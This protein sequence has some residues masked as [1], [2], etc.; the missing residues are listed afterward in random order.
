MCGRYDDD[1]S[2]ATHTRP[3]QGTNADVVVTLRDPE[4]LFEAPLKDKTA[5]EFI[6]IKVSTD[7]YPPEVR[8]MLCAGGAQASADDAVVC[9]CDSCSVRV[10][11]IHRTPVLPDPSPRMAAVGKGAAF[12]MSMLGGGGG[13]GPAL[14][15]LA[16][17]QRMCPS[18][19]V[20]E[21]DRMLNPFGLEMGDREEVRQVNGALVGSIAVQTFLLLTS[22]TIAAIMYHRLK[23]KE[24][25]ERNFGHVKAEGTDLTTEKR[26]TVFTTGVNRH[27]ITYLAARGR[28]GWILIPASFLYAGAAMCSMS[29]LLYST[30]LFKFIAAMDILIFL[31]GLI[32]YA[33]WVA[34]TLPGYCEVA[35][36]EGNDERNVIFK[37][38]WG[39]RE[40]VT[41]D[42]FGF[43]AWVELNHMLYDGYRDRFRF[44][45]TYELLLNLLLG[46]VGAWNPP[47]QKG[48]YARSI[49]TLTLM[50]LFFSLLLLGRPYLSPFENV[51]E[52]MIAG[53]EV[54]MLILMMI[55]TEHEDPET[56]VTSVIASY[57]GFAV[58][59]M[60]MTKTIGD[61]TIFVLDERAV[62][63]EMQEELPPG[64]RS[65]FIVHLL[66]CGNNIQG[67]A[68]EDVVAQRKQGKGVTEADILEDY[69]E[70]LNREEEAAEQ[71]GLEYRVGDRLTEGS[72][73]RSDS[74]ESN[75]S[76]NT[77]PVSAASAYE[78]PD[79]SAGLVSSPLATGRTTFGRSAFASS[80]RLPSEGST[81]ELVEEDEVH[82]PVVR[83]GT[84]PNPMSAR[85]IS[86]GLN[87]MQGAS[88]FGRGRGT[89]RFNSSGTISRKPSA[90]VSPVN[91]ASHRLRSGSMT[92]VVSE[93][94]SFLGDSGLE[95]PQPPTRR[96][97][98]SSAG[99]TTFGRG[100]GRSLSVVNSESSPEGLPRQLSTDSTM[101]IEL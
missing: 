71:E 23:G 87:T 49:V 83:R 36:C 9:T 24:E 90:G 91:D 77:M 38:F 4:A 18:S 8:E 63:K 95:L 17:L 10:E 72:G 26:T 43:P 42:G 82:V 75:G 7:L 88:V 47:N 19:D 48:C 50:I 22:V 67:L 76:G 54:A 32:A 51:M 101:M 52:T 56:H 20:I 68:M 70:L 69:R 57:L 12:T 55:A 85:N 64:E 16:I 45:L 59:Y 27:T 28:F 29:A 2:L 81:T 40:W 53:T 61:L 34:W 79:I 93:S 60:I 21:L 94:N 92:S 11:L 62:W 31:V 98:S 65:A 5:P 74:N 25:L 84:V 41:K 35:D 73:L 66:C 86:Y 46:F 96:R 33:L 99:F 30:P 39:L 1:L 97:E 6:T 15:K 89:S 58:I 44:F 37:F 3:P 13:A 80:A 100:R 14:V 78:A